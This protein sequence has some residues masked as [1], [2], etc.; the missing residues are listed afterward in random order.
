MSNERAAKGEAKRADLARKISI[1]H[2]ICAIISPKWF[3][4]RRHFK[5]ENRVDPSG[6]RSSFQRLILF[7]NKRTIQEPFKWNS[8]SAITRETPAR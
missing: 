2:C 1:I 6:P 7:A 5:R 4:S 3:T 8:N